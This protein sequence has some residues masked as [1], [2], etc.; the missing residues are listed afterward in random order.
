MRDVTGEMASLLGPSAPSACVRCGVA[1]VRATLRLQEAAEKAFQG[2]DG[3]MDGPTGFDVSSGLWQQRGWQELDALRKKLQELKVG[4]GSSSPLGGGWPLGGGCAFMQSVRHARGRGD[5]SSLPAPRAVSQW[6]RS[7][8]R[9]SLLT[10]SLFQHLHHTTEGVAHT[11]LHPL[12]ACW[13]RSCASWCASWGVA[14]GRCGPHE[15]TNSKLHALAAELVLRVFFLA[16]LC[17]A[18]PH[19][20]CAC[21]EART[22]FRERLLTLCTRAGSTGCRH[23]PK[24]LNLGVC[25]TCTHWNM[26]ECIVQ[27][28][29]YEYFPLVRT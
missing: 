18:S 25:A 28:N 23:A 20:R 16:G 1:D 9:T 8:S 4:R 26:S 3:L 24:V 21:T 15:A 2:L 19:I 7:V 29:S 10:Q 17:P 5:A 27:L 14:P 11:L 6:I 13:C 12:C 22:R